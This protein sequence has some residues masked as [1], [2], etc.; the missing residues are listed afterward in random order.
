M[1][2]RIK[3]I[4]YFM[5]IAGVSYHKESLARNIEYLFDSALVNHADVTRFNDGQ[6]LPGKYLV[7]VS[8]N[9]KRKN[10]GY[11]TIDFQYRGDVLSPNI[12]EGDLSSFGINPKKIN[13]TLYKDS[14]YIDFEKSDI[15]FYFSFFS[16]ALVFYVPR[17]SIVNGNSELAHESQWDDGINALYLNYDAKLYHRSVRY[18]A[19]NNESY[20]TSLEPGVNIG[21]WRI[22]SSGIWMKGY[23][24]DSKYESSY[25]Y[26]ERDLRS[27]KS[28]LLLGESSTGSEIF[29]SIPFKGIRLSTSDNMIPYFER[30]FVPTVRGVAN[31]VAQV[32]VRQNGYLIYSTEVPSGPFA[33]SDIPA[34]EGSDLEVTVT[35]DNGA[36]Q[37]FTVPFNAPAISIK[38]GSLRY[39]LT[40]GKYRPY[41]NTSQEDN[42]GH[43]TIIYGFNDLLTGYTGVQASNNYFSGA[44]GLGFNLYELGAVSLDSVYSRNGYND[45]EAGSAVRIRYNKLLSETNTSFNLA[46]YQYA[47]KNYSTFADSMESEKHYSDAWKK[48]ND[49][50][51]SIRQSFNNYGNVDLSLNKTTYWDQ[52]DES[53]ANFSYSTSLF[54]RAS[55]TIGW[56]RI[57]DSYYNEKEDVF[58]ASISIPFGR[59]LNTNSTNLIYQIVNERDDSISNSISLNG[60]TYDNR[61]SWGVSQGVNSKNSNNNRTAFNTSLR[62]S[63]GTMSAMYNYSRQLTQYG[64]GLNGSIV[65]HNQ[66]ITFG[67]RIHGAAALI[68][69]N[70]AENVSVSYKPGV[71]TDNKGFALVGGLSTYRKNNIYL[72]Q[73]NI[74]SATSIDKTISSVVPTDNAIVRAVFATTKGNKAIFKLLNKDNTPIK[75]GAVVN[76]SKKENAGIVGDDGKVYIT[77]LDNNGIL[78]VQWGKGSMDRCRVFYDLKNKNSFGLYS[79]TLKCM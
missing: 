28:K 27:L 75:F 45:D 10:H 60:L 24:G 64:G 53:Y 20:Y 70:G 34:S 14:D 32:D 11:Y 8:V 62:N 9:D 52:K 61:L 13:L 40:L 68:D 55:L 17:Q 29:D 71:V 6:Q 44:I 31:S 77:G 22:R 54:N 46:S 42:F 58:S 25:S 65:L 51:I 66:G 33:L 37:H 3:P 26:A 50:S 72:E 12:N 2:I 73:N 47:S 36:V 7:A 56:N 19:K 43:L 30:E 21:S 49:S 63:F 57:L 76:I 18:D 67:Q 4:I 48:K 15:K 59:W 5:M 74:N 41:Y 79:E 38:S 69:V 23:D 35:E 16:K 78:D 1:N 39:D